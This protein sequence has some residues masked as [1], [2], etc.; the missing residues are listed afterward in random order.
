[1]CTDFRTDTL[2]PSCYFSDSAVRYTIFYT[3]VCE[4]KFETGALPAMSIL[5]N[6]PPPRKFN[7]CR[8]KLLQKVPPGNQQDFLIVFHLFFLYS[9]LYSF[10]LSHCSQRYPTPTCRYGHVYTATV[11]CRLHQFTTEVLNT[12]TAYE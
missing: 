7:R 11:P 8:I 5:I 6:T 3:S 12:E 9:P 4:K 2:L 1:M 10:L